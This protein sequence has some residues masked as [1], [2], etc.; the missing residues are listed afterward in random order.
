[1]STVVETKCGSYPVTIAVP[2]SVEAFD[3][4]AKKQ[5]ACLDAAIWDVIY[6]VTLG[7]MRSKVEDLI[8]AEYGIKRREI[9]TGVFEGEGDEKEEVTK[10]EKWEVYLDRVAA[11]KAL[12]GEL[13]LRHIFAKV[14]HGGSHEVAL[15]PSVKERKAGAGA[16]LP[17]Y[18][19]AQAERF[20]DKTP[21]PKTGKVASLE[22]FFQA[23]E[24]MLDKDA[25][26]LTGERDK[27]IKLI[28]AAVVEYNNAEAQE[29]FAKF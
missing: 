14:S 18:A 23:Y 28:G 6:H 1:M 21:N 13:P 19:I 25:P 17:K 3:Q 16:K 24:K 27:D 29:R 26:T 9:G 4:L 11:E 2:D 10:T 7:D 5:G 22:K 12:H 8:D 20:F 15:D